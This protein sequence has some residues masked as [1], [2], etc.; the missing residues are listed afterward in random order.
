MSH[1]CSLLEDEYE[2]LLFLLTTATWRLANHTLSNDIRL[3]E[4]TLHEPSTT[5][6]TGWYI[7][8]WATSH[9]ECLVRLVGKNHDVVDTQI[10]SL[11]QLSCPFQQ[12]HSTLVID[13]KP[14][15]GS[16]IKM[17][18]HDIDLNLK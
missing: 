3:R 17:C 1:T 13:P 8:L 16:E 5:H 4:T 2:H 10:V 14:A 15:Q 11:L 7:C 9:N 12:V 6:D 18:R